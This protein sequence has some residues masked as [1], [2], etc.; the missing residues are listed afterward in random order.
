MK[1]L[2]SLIICLICS[3]GLWAAE[4]TVRQVAGDL[5][6]VTGLNGTAPLWSTLTV[7]NNAVGEVI[8]ELP[9]VLVAR[10]TEPNGIRI[11]SGDIVTIKNKGTQTSTRRAR[12]IVYATRVEQGPQIDG[13]LNDPVWSKAIPIEGFVQRDPNYWMPDSDQTVAR[14]LYDDTNI[15]F[16]F[17][18]PTSGT[19]DHVANNMRRDSELWGDD[20]IQIMLDTYNDRQN[21]FFFFVNPLG[22]QSDLMLSNEGRSYNSDWDCN[23]VSR[24]GQTDNRWTVEVEIPFNQLRFKQTDDMIWGINLSRYKA[25][26]NEA[27][28]LVVGEQS[29]STSERYL[30]TDIGELRGLKQIHARRPIQIKPYALSGTTKDFLIANPKENATL[31]AGL[32]LRYGITS[33]LTLDVSY[34]TD[35]A[36]VEGDQEQTNLTQFKLFF[37]EKREFFLEG[38]NLFDFGEPAIRRGSGST[39]PT[40]LFYSR[41]IGLA[42]GQKVP[43]LLGSKIAGKEGRTS[44][45]VLN[46]LTDPTSFVDANNNTVQIPRTNYSVFRIKRD[47]FA[48]SNVGFIAVNKQSDNPIGGWNSYNRSLGIDFSFSPNSKLNFQAFAARTWDSQLGRVG[49]AAFAFMNYRGK[50]YWARLKVL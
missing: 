10:I 50:S 34:N 37:P 35:F 49:N 38:A 42:E 12:R 43:I 33:N 23:W 2:F 21:G 30:L 36:Q 46:A 6:Y 8:K 24:T 17:D 20:N 27:M 26:Q 28:Q 47:V 4:G 18:C 11:K 39:P 14:I 15:Y 41:Q 45:G 48:R 19:S 5:V 31:E 25:R 1:T 3:T 29:S 22:A 40:L 7:G 9:D 16:S 44:I 32:D 13:N